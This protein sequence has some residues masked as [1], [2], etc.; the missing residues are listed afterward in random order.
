MT[1]EWVALISV[2]IVNG[3]VFSI[4]KLSLSPKNATSLTDVEARL[5]LLET[6]LMPIKK[7]ISETNLAKGLRPQR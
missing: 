2:I 3:T 6:E 4:L 7:H 5:S 1:W